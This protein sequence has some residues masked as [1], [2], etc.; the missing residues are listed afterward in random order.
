MSTSRRGA[1]IVIE[2]LDRSGKSTQADV[3]L[4]RLNA[5]G[6]SA[7][8]MKFPDRTTAIGQMINAYLQSKADLDDH[9][10]HLLFAANRWELA[11]TITQ[12]LESGTHVLCDRYS[13][14]G[15]AFSASKSALKHKE[16]I[17]TPSSSDIPYTNPNLSYIWCRDPERGLPAPDLTLFLDISPEAASAR[18]GYGEERYEKA[19]MQARVREVFGQIGN[20]MLSHNQNED[21]S[22]PTKDG[23]Q[24][25][26]VVIDAGNDKT[27]VSK[28]MWAHVEPLIAGVDS[29]IGRLWYSD[30]N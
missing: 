25:R 10:I 8:L 15:I 23:A 21:R 4:D 12:T 26:W 29:P 3:M 5:S 2:G 24:P 19:E 13:F 6:I 18:G 20:E 27:T 11:S 22:E 1:F 9:V 14:S 17:P 30:D 16:A 28:D 7:K